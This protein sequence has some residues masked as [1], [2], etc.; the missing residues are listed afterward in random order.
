M[1]YEVNRMVTAD[2]E[3]YLNVNHNTP[4]QLELLEGLPILLKIDCPKQDVST[5]DDFKFDLPIHM[6]VLNKEEAMST[7]FQ[8]Y[9]SMNTKQ[10]SKANH[11]FMAEKKKVKPQSTFKARFH[12]LEPELAKYPT[13]IFIQLI[14]AIEC[15]V[16]VNI[17]F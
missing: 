1:K 10:P 5:L 15:R 3:T 2:S 11:D 6:L 12:N 17:S 7:D 14:S 13:T 8:A 16:E 4:K 9:F